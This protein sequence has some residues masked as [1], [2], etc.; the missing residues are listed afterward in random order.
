MQPGESATYYFPPYG[1]ETVSPS[2]TLERKL[3]LLLGLRAECYLFESQELEARI[4][5]GIPSP[6]ERFS[7]YLRS[8][9][10]RAFILP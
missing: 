4:Y 10:S 8:E 7:L 5:L 1:N 3:G 9:R 2:G 6:R